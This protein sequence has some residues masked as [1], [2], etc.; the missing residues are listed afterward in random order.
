MTNEIMQMIKE[1]LERMEAQQQQ[2]LADLG[3]QLADTLQNLQSEQKQVLDY[4]T[5]QSQ[6]RD[7]AIGNYETE[8]NNLRKSLNLPHRET[9]IKN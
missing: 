9:L 1:S 7:Q 8:L 3:S 5:R 4:L 6:A 2:V